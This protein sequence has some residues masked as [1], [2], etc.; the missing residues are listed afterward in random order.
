M[1]VMII[2]LLAVASKSLGEVQLQA[3]M[4]AR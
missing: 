1:G 2:I 4:A 3:Y